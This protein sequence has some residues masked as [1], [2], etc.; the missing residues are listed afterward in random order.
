M[1]VLTPEARDVLT[2]GRL[3]HLVTVNPPRH[4]DRRLLTVVVPDVPVDELRQLLA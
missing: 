1:T 3:V 4:I 2:A